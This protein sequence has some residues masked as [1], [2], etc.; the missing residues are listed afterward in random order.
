[1]ASLQELR[2]ERIKKLNTLKEKGINPY[3]SVSRRNETIGNIISDY[4]ASEGKEFVLS[5]RI[6]S[7]R[8]HGDLMFL[9]LVDA[10]GKI[11]VYIK[12]DGLSETSEENQ[13]VGFDDMGLLDT[14]DFLDVEGSITKT[15]RGEVSI[16]A[17]NIYLIAKS[18]R[19]LPDKH[20]GLKDPE[21]I[22]RRRYLDLATNPESRQLFERKNKFW[23]AHRQ[24]LDGKGFMEIQTPVLEY[25]TG[26]ADARPFVTHHNALDQDFYL[27]ISLELY[28]KR[29][30]GGGYEKVYHI[31]PV[32]RNEGIDDEHLQEFQMLEWYWA[33]ADYR[34]N[35]ELSKELFRHVANEVYGTTKFENDGMQFDLADDWKEIDYTESIKDRFGIDIFTASEEEMEDLLKKEKVDLDGPVNRNRLIDSLWKVIRK[36]ISGPAFLVNEPKFMSPLAKSRT[37]NPELTE[38]FHIILAG[39]EVANAYSELNDPIDQFDRFKE[40]QAAR[41]AGDDESQMM[42][43]DFVEMLE[44]GMPPVSGYGHSERLFAFLEGL[45]VREATAFPQMR[46]KIDDTTKDIYDM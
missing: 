9:D 8:G 14:G 20:D 33:Y 23:R 26:G 39:S 27:R 35:M 7:H 24:F 40:Q 13:K 22:F 42:D 32:F 1:V 25:V 30:I 28:L 16:E 29:L 5:G 34:D 4:E 18:L 10:S 6:M 12:K 2:E 45:S 17:K 3:P 21:T 36:D 37:D 11:Q 15:K 38:R 44:Y 41:D 31:G 46:H 19:P 43:I